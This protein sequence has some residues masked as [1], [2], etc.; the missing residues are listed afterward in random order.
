MIFFV[1]LS[2]NHLHWHLF[3]LPHT[4]YIQTVRLQQLHAT[5]TKV[6]LSFKKIAIPSFI[7]INLLKGRKM[8]SNMKTGTYRYMERATVA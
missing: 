1:Y 5:A 3:Y 7:R 4:L 6:N 8:F 2:V